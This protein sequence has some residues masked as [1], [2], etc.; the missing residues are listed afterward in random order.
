MDVLHVLASGDGL[1]GGKNPAL[2]DKQG[3]SINVAD[4]L[5]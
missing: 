4:T 5:V 1:V 2:V 3:L